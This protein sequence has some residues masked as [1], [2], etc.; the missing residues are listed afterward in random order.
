M[1]ELKNWIRF[2]VDIYNENFELAIGISTKKRK[3]VCQ[4]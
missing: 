2:F 4:I 3:R 1:N